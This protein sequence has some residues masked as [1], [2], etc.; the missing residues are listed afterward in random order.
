[1]HWGLLTREDL[2][3]RVA[4]LSVGQQRKVELRILVGSEPDVLLLDEPTNHLIFDVIESLQAAL[5]DFD[6]PVLI[7]TH[8]R[9]LIREFPRRLWRLH[10]G[11]LA[12][13]EHS[14]SKIG[15]EKSAR[16]TYSQTESPIS[17]YPVT[18]SSNGGD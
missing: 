3:K 18:G 14:G 9:R 2:T 15:L 5:I 1:M 11:R 10:E 7:A 6:G 12:E 8:D 16:I 4:D 13:V 17:K